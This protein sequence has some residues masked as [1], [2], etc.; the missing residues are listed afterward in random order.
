MV[1]LIAIFSLIFWNISALAAEEPNWNK[2]WKSFSELASILES[3]PEGKTILQ[4]AKKKDPQFLTKIRR[5]N[6]SFTESTFSRAYSLLD[7]RE[8]IQV[9][10]EVTLSEQLGLAEAVADFAHELVHFA[11]K[12][13]L[14]PYREGFELKE[15]VERG[16]EGKGGELA[17][18]EKECQVAWALERKYATYPKHQLCAPYRGKK[19]RFL[20]ENARS[21]YY[22]LG[23][24]FR[25]T[26]KDFAKTFPLVS[27]RDVHFNSSYAGKPYPVAL[28]EEYQTTRKAACD[29][30]RRKYHLIAAQSESRAP[31]SNDLR[32]ERERLKGYELRYCSA[33]NK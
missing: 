20:K 12:E 30:N 28:W 7:G 25:K 23:T 21:D 29:N 17:A 11:E 2:Q 4:N 31:A 10:H 22:A 8:Q 6:A 27:E 32:K 24:W 19:E 16:I 5:G 33:E 13:M 26:P 15:F 3:I 18:L 9:H 1:G 14:D